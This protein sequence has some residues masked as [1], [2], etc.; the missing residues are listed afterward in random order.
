LDTQRG[1]ILEAR[2]LPGMSNFP[3]KARL[4]K[5]FRIPAFIG[6]DAKA[7]ALAEQRFGAGRGVAYMIYMTISTGIG[8]GIIADG[9]IYQGWRGFAGEVG[10]QTLEPRGPRCTCGNYGDLEALA[11]GP[12]IERDAREA[13]RAGRDSRMRRMVD[14]DLDKL[15]GAVVTQA[16]RE[17]DVLACE[18]L[19][20]AGTYIGMGIANLLQILDTQLFV[21]GG[22][23]AE[24]AWE[25]LYPAMIAELDKRAMPSMRAGVQV[26]QAQLGADVVLLGAAVLAIDNMPT[27]R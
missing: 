16:A 19:A 21:L 24:N 22:S 25:F 10:H 14:D 8:G 12:A 9:K 2:N 1:I 4:E 11:S 7:A 18:L 3:M 26:I 27:H 20:R 23:V 17:G 5:E 15:T 6:H 13:L